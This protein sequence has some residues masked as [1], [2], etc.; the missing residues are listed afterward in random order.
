MS[1]PEETSETNWSVLLDY[2]SL[3]VGPNYIYIKASDGFADNET[4][5]IL[6][7]AYRYDLELLEFTVPTEGTIRHNFTV[8]TKVLNKG[9]HDTPAN[10]VLHCYIGS[11]P[12]EKFISVKAGE[13]KSYD[14]SFN[15][16]ESGVYTGRAIVNPGMMAEEEDSTNNELTSPSNITVIDPSGGSGGDGGDE[17]IFEGN[18]LLVVVGLLMVLFVITAVVYYSFSSKQPSG[19]PK[20]FQKVDQAPIRDL[21]GGAFMYEHTVDVGKL[22]ELAPEGEQD[23]AGEAD[24]SFSP[25]SEKPPESPPSSPPSLTKKE[26]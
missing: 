26:E 24:S 25:P 19:P 14:F 17:S 16:A 2:R 7:F 23:G 22:E 12:K 8:S 21:S 9:P 3:V 5:A 6:L 15:M 20:P 10:V 11:I 13:T 1:L 4:F 18:T